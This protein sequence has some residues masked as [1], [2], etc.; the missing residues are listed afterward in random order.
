[1]TINNLK[2]KINFAKRPLLRLQSRYDGDWWPD[3]SRSNYY[4]CI[5][6]NDKVTGRLVM[7]LKPL[8]IKYMHTNNNKNNKLNER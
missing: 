3:V 5:V 8:G 1:M 4:C 7:P 2:G 6:I